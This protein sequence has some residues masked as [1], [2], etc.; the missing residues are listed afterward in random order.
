MTTDDN[1]DLLTFIHP[2]SGPDIPH[3][4][5]QEALRAAIDVFQ[6]RNIMS[7]AAISAWHARDQHTQVWVM[8]A[9][10]RPSPLSF[11]DYQ[12]TIQ[13]PSASQLM[14]AAAQAW[15]DAQEAATKAVLKRVPNARSV[16]WYFERVPSPEQ[17]RRADARRRSER[18]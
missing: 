3:A 15:D 9:S 14:M 18:V 1:S 8:S 5:T 7:A 17:R 16:D 13:S 6:T 2:S 11:D 4:V 12:A 10:T